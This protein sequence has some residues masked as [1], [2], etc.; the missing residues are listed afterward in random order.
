MKFTKLTS[1]VLAGATLLSI[2]APTASFAATSMAGSRDTASRDNGTGKDAELPQ[3]GKTIAGISFG[4]NTPLP[5]SGYLRLQMVPKF[6][7]FGN[8]KLVDDATP[9]FL[10]NGLNVDAQGDAVTSNNKQVG[11][12][13]TDKNQTQPLLTEDPELANVK[14][15]AWAT[16]VDK[17]ATRVDSYSHASN[18]NN[19]NDPTSDFYEG[20][21]SASGSW[22]LDVK[23]DD[24][25]HAVDNKGNALPSGKPGNV[26]SDAVLS[27]NNTKYDR[28]NEVYT[29][30]GE[31]QDSKYVAPTTE[32]AKD[33]TKFINKAD[34]SDLDNTLA[35]TL[36]KPAT[37]ATGTG[38][39]VARAGDGEG[40]GANVFGWMPED[41]KLTMPQGAKVNNAI[42]QTSLTWTLVSDVI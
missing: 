29:L 17:Q 30:T 40:Q 34:G 16:V 39:V 38:T 14:G 28:T 20:T 19:T 9:D 24:N 26:V 23:A 6:L 2:M 8:H 12:D 3:T 4:D 7:D 21:T 25:L 35:L 11:F 18:P 42:Y 37:G 41:I 13:N 33:V 27:F 22:H 32:T 31:S 1:S 36:E 10:A 15:T 5:N